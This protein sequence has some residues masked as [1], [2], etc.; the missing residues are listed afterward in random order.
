MLY[1]KC[2]LGGLSVVVFK[3]KVTAFKLQGGG[4][5]PRSVEARPTA[6]RHG[7]RRGGGPHRRA[8]AK[9][10]GGVQE[11]YRGDEETAGDVQGSREG[12]RGWS[13]LERG[14]AGP[15]SAPKDDGGGIDE[16]SFFLSPRSPSCERSERCC[17]VGFGKESKPLADPAT[18]LSQE[19]PEALRPTPQCPLAEA[20]GASR[21]EKIE[22]WR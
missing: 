9:R 3:H 19:Q 8:E 13:Q 15:G 5:G 14:S 2:W 1:W 17:A 7:R 18:V 11:T 10:A 12:V 6:E 4:G 21:R 22:P 20:R 16:A